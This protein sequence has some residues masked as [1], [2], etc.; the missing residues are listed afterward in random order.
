MSG[1]FG[2]IQF[3]GAP[4]APHLSAMQSA[5]AHWGPDG[6]RTAT[7]G[8]AAFGHCHLVSTPEAVH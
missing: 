6:V 2:V 5:M 8:S 1:I 3:D 7:Q 4:V